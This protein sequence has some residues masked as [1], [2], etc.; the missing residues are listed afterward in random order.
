MDWAGDMALE[1][2]SHPLP[3]LTPEKLREMLQ[4]AMGMQLKRW[5][6]GFSNL[7]SQ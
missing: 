3:G 2:V 5:N 4:Q 6:K 7:P 1:G